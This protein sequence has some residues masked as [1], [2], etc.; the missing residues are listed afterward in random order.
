MTPTK[1]IET[2]EISAEVEVKPPK[3]F[4]VLSGK[5]RVAKTT[6]TESQAA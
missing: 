6:T 3:P 5:A 1:Q 2:K 4:D